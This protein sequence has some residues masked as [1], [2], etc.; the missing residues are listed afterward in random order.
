MRR[1]K[2]TAYHEAGHAVAGAVLLDIVAAV[3]IDGREGRFHGDRI[4]VSTIDQYTHWNAAVH[5]LAG[6]YA[7]ARA[8]KCSRATAI[9]RGG[10][11]DMA[12]AKKIIEHLVANGF[13]RSEDDAWERADAHADDFLTEHWQAIERVA[14]G[15][16]ERGRLEAPE[17]SELV[18]GNE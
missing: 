3:E 14:L 5:C 2:A 7:E 17:V 6:P 8:A 13:S 12:H 11:D 15:L 18:R 16:I 10:L 9:W 1:H 4:I